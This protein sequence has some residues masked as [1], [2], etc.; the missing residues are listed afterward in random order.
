[1]TA[2]DAITP[3]T[4]TEPGTE[5]M[6]EPGTEPSTAPAIEVSGLTRRFRHGV[7]AL[8]D[9]TLSIRRD[10]IVGLLGRNGAGKTTLM[11]LLTGQDFPSA[12]RISVLGGNPLENE[13]ILGQ[14]CFIRESQQYPNNF[15]LRH[16][17]AAGRG[18]YPCWDQ[19]LAE[20]LVERFGLPLRREVNRL[21]RGMR[22]S[23]GILVGLASRAPVTF[24]DEPYL[25]LDASARAQFYDLLLAEYAEHPRTI[26][27]ST[28]LIDE[29]AGLLE[30][31]IVLD[32]GQVA[33]SGSAEE[34]S[35]R[36][37]VLTGPA[38][39]V[40][41]LARDWTVLHRESVGGYLVLTV[42]VPF[43]PCVRSLAEQYGV[44]TSPISL[45]TLAMR[46]GADRRGSS[47]TGV[48]R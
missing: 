31:V 29:V 25:G 38:N 1:M 32:G 12:G 35:R 44:E 17:L 9:V 41:T 39:A 22:S 10:T 8:D 23:V 37:C 4:A 16:V 36:G 5:P 15:H 2:P 30:D 13:A 48:L 45:Q 20:D 27:L 26:V 21:S 42:D 11:S 6:S 18:F 7:V 34:L 19:D 43:D 28:H 33:L 3:E 24:F 47:T 40:E 46:A 14:L